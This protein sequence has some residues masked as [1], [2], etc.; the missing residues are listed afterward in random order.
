MKKSTLFTG[1]AFWKKKLNANLLLLGF[2]ALSL[3]VVSCQEDDIETPSI[4]LSEQD[5]TYARETSYSNLAEVEMGQLALTKT[6]N[7]SVREFAELMVEDHSNSQAELMEL[8]ASLQI[9][10]PDTLN[11]EERLI[12]EG[13]SI[14]EGAAFDVAYM[15]AQV[16]AHEESHDLQQS[17]V[18]QGLNVRLREFANNAYNKIH[19]HLEM[20]RQLRDQLL[21]ND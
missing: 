12:H 17:Q 13:L 7:P 11:T 14:L 16:V 9:E 18:D 21:I 6:N 2:A 1:S 10:I 5:R 8:A 15:N 19:M 20:A 3:G 4:N